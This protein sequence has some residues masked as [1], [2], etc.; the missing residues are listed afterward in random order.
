MSESNYN[1]QDSVQWNID[2]SQDLYDKLQSIWRSN[3]QGEDNED[4]DDSQLVVDAL[5]RY[6]LFM[7]A[8]KN[9]NKSIAGVE[10]SETD[11]EINEILEISF[12]CYQLKKKLFL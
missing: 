10:Q 1:S 2:I 6:V 9:R 8:Q 11:D 7:T 4:V 5:S 3:K 12:K